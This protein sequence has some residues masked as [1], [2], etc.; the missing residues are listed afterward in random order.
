MMNESQSHGGR[1]EAARMKGVQF[2]FR[3]DM[4]EEERAWCRRFD[5]ITFLSGRRRV[6]TTKSRG[7]R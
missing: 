7:T 1:G 6:A 2:A 4:T 3:E 5:K